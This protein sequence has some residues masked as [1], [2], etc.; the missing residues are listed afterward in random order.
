MVLFLP[1]EKKIF[2]HQ[3]RECKRLT[4]F[5][6]WPIKKKK[7][8]SPLVKSHRFPFGS[9]GPLS[10]SRVVCSVA[11]VASTQSSN[12][13]KRVKQGTGQMLP[14]PPEQDLRV[15]KPGCPS[16]FHG[17][18][19]HQPISTFPSQPYSFSQIIRRTQP[20]KPKQEV[21]WGHA[22]RGGLCH[23][24]IWTPPVF[25]SLFLYKE[26]FLS[27][28]HWSNIQMSLLRHLRCVQTGS[29]GTVSA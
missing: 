10:G 29:R 12:W 5:W 27:P 19:G 21:L 14:E 24:A 11:S 28:R 9:G 15:R 25:S 26:G 6:I 17:A 20:Y 22:G 3:K 1:W 16:A 18:R 8:K 2:Y 7:K 13:E 4:L 23:Q